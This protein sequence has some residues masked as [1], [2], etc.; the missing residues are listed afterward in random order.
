MK[1]RSE[2]CGVLRNDSLRDFEGEHH[3]LGMINVREMENF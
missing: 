3:V 2:P 1:N